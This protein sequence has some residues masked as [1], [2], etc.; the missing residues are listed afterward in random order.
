M[1]CILNEDVQYI[2]N[3]IQL[4]IYRGDQT[5]LN[6]DLLDSLLISEAWKKYRDAVVAW[7]T[8]YLRNYSSRQVRTWSTHAPTLRP[9]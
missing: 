9:V 1:K 8:V 4:V 2:N 6:I 3:L 7:T 5:S